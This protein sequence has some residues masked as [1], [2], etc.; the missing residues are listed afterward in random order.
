MKEHEHRYVARIEKKHTLDGGNI[1]TLT[2]HKHRCVKL[3]KK[4]ELMA[5]TQLL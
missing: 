1:V 3:S 5:T 4:H 2:K